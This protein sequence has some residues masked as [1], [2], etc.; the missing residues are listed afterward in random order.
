MADPTGTTG[1]SSVPAKSAPARRTFTAKLAA[2]PAARATQ[3]SVPAAAAVTVTTSVSPAPSRALASTASAVVET[4]AASAP[5]DNMP[6][7]YGLIVILA[8]MVAILVA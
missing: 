1:P 7:V 4:P 2:K 8:G 5:G 6:I 3:A